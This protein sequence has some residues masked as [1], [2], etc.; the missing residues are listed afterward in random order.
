MDRWNH[1]KGSFQI[2]QTLWIPTNLQ[3]LEPDDVVVKASM[4]LQE[5]KRI[6]SFK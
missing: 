4:F 5:A 6:N 3:Q 1:H 2:R